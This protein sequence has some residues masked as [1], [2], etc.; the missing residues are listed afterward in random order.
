MPDYYITT[1]KIVV[2]H[3]DDG[4]VLA[5][6]LDEDP[7]DLVQHYLKGWQGIT[8]P[9]LLREVADLLEDYATE[10]WGKERQ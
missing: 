9:Q 4:C 5:E 3:F 2:R 6:I 1:V 8:H 7:F 10:E